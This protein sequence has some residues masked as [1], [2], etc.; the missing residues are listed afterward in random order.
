MR[1]SKGDKGGGRPGGE[2]TK[3]YSS[4]RI[5]GGFSKDNI[6]TT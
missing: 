5:Q 4:P 6:P 2:K 1:V 3:S